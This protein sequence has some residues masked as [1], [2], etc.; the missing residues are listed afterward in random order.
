MKSAGITPGGSF[1]RMLAEHIKDSGLLQIW[2]ANKLGVSNTFISRLKTD[3]YPTFE[4]LIGMC[5]LMRISK[6]KVDA[7]IHQYMVCRMHKEALKARKYLL[8]SENDC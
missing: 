5:K 4:L 8:I 2:I 7:L 6:K 1:N 3:R